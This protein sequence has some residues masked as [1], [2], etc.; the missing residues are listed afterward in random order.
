MTRQ[1]QDG[2]SFTARLGDVLRLT[3]RSLTPLM[4]GHAL[5]T[6]TIELRC[7]VALSTLAQAA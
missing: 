5:P 1:G 2:F 7:D 3:V 6:L 4:P